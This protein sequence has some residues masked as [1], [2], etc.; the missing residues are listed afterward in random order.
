MIIRVNGEARD[1]SSSTL[2]EL[3]EDF[4]LAAERVAIEL[5]HEVI[6]RT[7]WRETVLREDDRVEIVH[8]VGGGDGRQL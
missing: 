4:K 3:V 1:V 2:A 7:L 8:F 6:R 5:N